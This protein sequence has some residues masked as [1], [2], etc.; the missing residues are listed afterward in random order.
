MKYALVTTCRN[1]IGNVLA[2]KQDVLSQTLQPDEIS[3]VDSCSTDGTWEVLERW[4]KEDKRLKIFSIQS[5]PATGRNIAFSK[6]RSE[7]IA[8][9]DMGCRLDK[10]WFLEIT[11][12]FRERREIEIVAG[13][14]EADKGSIS[15]NIGWADY[16]LNNC[17]RV[18]FSESFLPSNRSV[19]YKKD[20]WI[21][22]G[23]L[24]E[25]LKFAGDDTELGLKILESKIKIEFA[26]SAIVYW[27]RY[28]KLDDLKKEK[29]RYG[30]A[31]GEIGKNRPFFSLPP[32]RNPLF[33]L[34]ELLYRFPKRR[35]FWGVCNALRNRKFSAAILILP[36]Y[37]I[38]Q[39]EFI[40][41][42]NDGYYQS[43]ILV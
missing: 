24:P 39:R 18:E 15:S 19:A 36:L 40:I 9:T 5:N 3:I 14:F 21:R 10:N 30:F 34:K 8:S 20:I 42:L 17:Y 7:I 26:P 23:G 28:N 6:S 41:G 22:L 1:E 43:R 13:F 38:T 31:D 37:F 16:F 33:I 11:E 27:G 12:P 4:A 2:W 25:A 35:F 29:Y 32:S